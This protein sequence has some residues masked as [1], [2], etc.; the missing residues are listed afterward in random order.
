MTAENIMTS[1]LVTLKAEDTVADAVQ[2]LHSSHVRNLPVVDSAGVFV[3]LFGLRRLSRLLLPIAASDLGRHSIVDLHFLPDD[4]VL[5]S[6]RWHEIASQPVI[7]YLEKNKKLLFCTPQTK[8][9]E[10]LAMLDNS[11]DATLPVII[12]EG[13]TH[14]L[15]GVVSVWDVLEGI[16]LQRLSKNSPATGPAAD[17]A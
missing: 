17:D 6:D 3:G 16:I 14:K 9:P 10:L 15:V 13:D 12:V 1:R 11:K 8:F 5:A 7:N 2:L 4:S